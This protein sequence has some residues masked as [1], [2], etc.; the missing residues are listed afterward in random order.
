[1]QFIIDAMNGFSRTSGSHHRNDE[2]LMEQS[3]KRLMVQAK[4]HG[5]KQ[6]ASDLLKW[7]KVSSSEFLSFTFSFS[8][9]RSTAYCSSES[10]CAHDA[11]SFMHSKT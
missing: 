10:P 11:Q 1:M 3:K 4:D 2:F 5:A 9:S 8:N 6:G 7:V